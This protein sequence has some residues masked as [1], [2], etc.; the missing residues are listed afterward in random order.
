MNIENEEKLKQQ[1]T[2]LRLQIL[3]E[4]GE[5]QVP[6]FPLFF[7]TLRPTNLSLSKSTRIFNHIIL[8]EEFQVTKCNSAQCPSSS[9]LKTQNDTYTQHK[10]AKIDKLR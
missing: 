9:P 10:K 1:I 4:E 8:A 3:D 5:N 7:P 2:E 6:R